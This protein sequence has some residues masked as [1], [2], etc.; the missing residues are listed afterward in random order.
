MEGAHKDI[1]ASDES[2]AGVMTSLMS[3]IVG[4]ELQHRGERE[5]KQALHI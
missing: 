2:E 1:E 4:S 5:E 3:I